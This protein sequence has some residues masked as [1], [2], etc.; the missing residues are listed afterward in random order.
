M[1]S[2]IAQVFDLDMNDDEKVFKAIIEII[3]MIENIK[4]LTNKIESNSKDELVKLLT[5]FEKRIMALGLEDDIHKLDNIITNEILISIN[6]LALAL[7][8]CNQYR[9]I[10]E[11]NLN[12]FREKIRNL[13]DELEDLEVNNELKL[14]IN[15]VLYDLYI[16]IEEYK[17]YGIEGLKI[18]IE[19]GLGSIMLNRNICEE[20]SKNKGFKESIK[21]ILSLL[22]SINTTI[23]FAKNIIPIAQEANDIVNRLLD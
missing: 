10:E 11:E 1:E 16:R 15:N 19:Q 7:D 2:V 12:K 18:S 14:F 9:D 4:K 3:Q 13:I 17:I 8:V 23:S 20:A 5:N 21:K 6:G 22:T